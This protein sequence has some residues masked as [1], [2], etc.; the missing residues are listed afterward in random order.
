MER[1][2]QGGSQRGT[3]M[4]GGNRKDCIEN[5]TLENK[6]VKEKYGPQFLPKHSGWA[7]LS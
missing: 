4:F 6:N 7:C 1:R 5:K 2:T 3:K